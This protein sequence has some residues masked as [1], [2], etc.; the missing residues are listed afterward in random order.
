MIAAAGLA[1]DAYAHFDLASTYSG[2]KSSVLSQGDVFRAEATVSA[3]AAAVLLRPRRDAAAFG[4]VVATAGT[5]TV[6]S[7]PTSILAH[8]GRSQTCTASALFTS[9]RARS[10]L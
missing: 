10:K 2:V 4:C 9:V 1:I 3:I 8:L 5:A 6:L 7:M